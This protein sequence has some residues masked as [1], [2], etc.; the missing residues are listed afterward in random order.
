M[1]RARITICSGCITEFPDNDLYT[2][3]RQMHRGQPDKGYYRTPY[4]EK[5]IK[6]KDSYHEISQQPK[7]KTKKK[8]K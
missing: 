3:T 5:C 8:K 6:D 7:N 1:A 2:V 4:C